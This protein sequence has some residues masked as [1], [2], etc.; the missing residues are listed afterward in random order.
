M[1]K[2][3]S[4]FFVSM[5][6]MSYGTAHAASVGEVFTG[7]MLGTDQRYFESVAGIARKSNGNDHEFK[8]QGCNITAT[9][10]GGTVTRLRMELAPNCH[11][12][13]TKFVGD[14]A[15]APGKPL[16]LGAFDA[17]SGGGGL[18][19]A[20][21]CLSD[22]GNSEVPSVYAYWEGPHAVN[23]KNVMLEVALS[24]NAASAAAENWETQIQQPK[25]D[26]SVEDGVMERRFTCD[27]KSAPIIQK[28]FENV[29]VTAVSIGR[30]STAPRGFKGL[31]C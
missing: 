20:V 21:D 10:E 18:I 5:L 23:Y 16:T 27:P 6:T 15:P 22:C 13:L 8:V 24:S 26:D 3:A 9:I 29:P 19:Y 7:D 28:A 31:R 25:G 14:Y 2:M 17:T 12:D 4:V 1:N 11:A 30:W